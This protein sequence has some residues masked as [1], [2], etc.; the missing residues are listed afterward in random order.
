MSKSQLA[1]LSLLGL[2]TYRLDENENS[3]RRKRFASGAG[4]LRNATSRD[5]V[6]V[7]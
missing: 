4:L 2:D 6:S 7:S 3:P 5:A 1:G